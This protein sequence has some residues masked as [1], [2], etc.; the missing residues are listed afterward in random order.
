MAASAEVVVVG[1]GLAGLAAAR[2]LHR[3]GVAVRV[4]EAAERVGGRVATD[5]VDLPVRL[6]SGRY[7]CGDHRDTP[8]I[9]GALVSG[10]RAARAVL[11]DLGR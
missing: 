7:V 10:R 11:A 9:R 8:S 6:G 3:A 4:C 5:E 2:H 1:A